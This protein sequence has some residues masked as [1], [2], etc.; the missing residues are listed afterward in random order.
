MSSNLFQW[1]TE[2]ELKG[3]ASKCHL[4]ICSDENVHVNIGSSHI[5]NSKC[6]RLLGIDIDFKLGFENH[7]NQIRSKAR[8]KIK[9]LGRIVPSLNKRK[10]KL[11]MNAFFKSQ[12]LP[13]MAHYHRCFIAVHEQQVNRLHETCLRIM[14]NDNTSPF[15]DLLEKDNSVSVRHRNIQVLQS[16]S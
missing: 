7:I 11:L 3:N 8:A 5:K 4:L 2:K 10:R 6:E 9:S 12:L 13:V 15:T 1:L 16:F 14:Y